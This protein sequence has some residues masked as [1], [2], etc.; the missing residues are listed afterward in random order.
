MKSLSLSHLLFYMSS[1][2]MKPEQ[3][4]INAE[5]VVVET[6]VQASVEQTENKEI[7]SESP[8]FCCGSCS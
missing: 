8:S 5:N 4:D 3:Q 7:K 2:T 1:Q 6:E